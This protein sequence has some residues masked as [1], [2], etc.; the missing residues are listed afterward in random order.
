LSKIPASAPAPAPSPTISPYILKKFPRFQIFL[1]LLR[2]IP[3]G[4]LRKYKYKKKMFK[5]DINLFVEKWMI[6]G[7]ILYDFYY[8]YLELEPAQKFRLRPEQN[9][10]APPAPAPQ[11][12][13]LEM[14]LTP[15]G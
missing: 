2:Q 8:R 5:F 9:V 11:H 6:F 10:A 7:K 14:F 4:P 12:W 15:I 1:I 3:K 13:F